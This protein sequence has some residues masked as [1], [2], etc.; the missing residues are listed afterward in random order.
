MCPR[1]G[2][3]SYRAW[4]SHAIMMK[5]IEFQVR[6]EPFLK[7]QREQL[8]RE[9]ICMKEEFQFNGDTY[10]IDHLE[11]GPNS[12]E[13]APMPAGKYIAIPP[14]LGS[15]TPQGISLDPAHGARIAQV[16]H[17]HA[18]KLSDLSED[19][20]ASILTTD[21]T[22]FSRLWMGVS[23]TQ[24]AHFGVQYDSLDIGPLLSSLP[25]AEQIE[26]KLN[27]IVAGLLDQGKINPKYPLEPLPPT[28]TTE[29]DLSTLEKL[30]GAAPIV[31]NAGVTADTDG[32]ALIF[33]IELQGPFL[34][35]QAMW[36]DFYRTDVPVTLGDAD[37]SVV[38]SPDVF[39]RA[40]ELKIMAGLSQAKVEGKFEATD[41]GPAATWQPDRPGL[42]IAFSGLVPDACPGFVGP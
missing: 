28:E 25:N 1:T 31:S 42:D 40:T 21:I 16:I 2:G 18:A 36:T 35:S 3:S 22:I 30:L 39:V 41:S 15:T 12:V 17:V 19:P 27:S 9:T 7:Q 10:V 32:A 8:L 26:D 24:S 5:I 14:P 23:P 29:I 34:G 33:R 4:R 11:I 37:W 38:V 13:R 6:S 20:P